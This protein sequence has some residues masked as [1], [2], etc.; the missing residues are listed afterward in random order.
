MTNLCLRAGQAV[1]YAAQAIVEVASNA[2]DV[3][4]C[5]G[6]TTGGGVG[7]GIGLGETAVTGPPGIGLGVGTGL[8]TGWK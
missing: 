3:D 2:S 4:I 7:E 8:G 6:L 1:S 5:R